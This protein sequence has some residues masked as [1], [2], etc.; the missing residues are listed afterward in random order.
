MG[1]WRQHHGAGATCVATRFF[2][3]ASSIQMLPANQYR[4]SYHVR[5]YATGVD[6]GY[7]ATAV[8]GQ[9]CTV[10]PN[11]EFADEYYTGS[12]QAV[13]AGTVPISSAKS[14]SL[15]PRAAK[16]SCRCPAPRRRH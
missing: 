16:V 14:P 11:T 6:L 9:G 7:A 12:V 2:A 3:Q 1:T 15:V 10:P 4:V 13:A 5:A 8:V